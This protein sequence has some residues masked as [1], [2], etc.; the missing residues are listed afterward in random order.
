MQLWN[1]LKH[2][3]TSQPA[4]P[5][6]HIALFALSRVSLKH[7]V[8]KC[9]LKWCLRCFV[10][11]AFS[12]NFLRPQLCRLP[13]SN[14]SCE[15]CR[16]SSTNS[17]FKSNYKDSAELRSA[18]LGEGKQLHLATADA[19]LSFFFKFLHLMFRS[20]CLLQADLYH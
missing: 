11:G 14:N 16:G 1:I 5:V 18:P 7:F 3:Q 19:G 6:S 20:P 10:I 2:T 15:Y 4:I 8:V 13:N 17:I 9:W 12:S